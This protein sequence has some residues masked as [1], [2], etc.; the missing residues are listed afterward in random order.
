MSRLPSTGPGLGDGP[1]GAEPQPNWA[2]AGESYS[3]LT[4][5]KLVLFLKSHIRRGLSGRF[6]VLTTLGGLMRT[7]KLSI[8]AFMLG[9]AVTGLLA[10]VAA[11]GSL[12][13]EK[14]PP[15]DTNDPTYRLF[16][17][18]DTT[19][20]GEL[21]SFS[22]LGDVY[23]DPQDPAQELQHVFKIEYDKNRYFGR[24]RIYVRSVSKL[25]PQQLKTYTP[26]QIFDFGIKDEEKFEKI[27][28][29]PFGQPGDLY[30]QA[31]GDLPLH[32]APTTDAVRKAYELFVSQYVLP[33]LQ[34]K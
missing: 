19:R 27:E 13:R 2:G 21:K 14:T 12:G 29:G 25:S 11:P 4:H 24:F 28:P 10:T 34:K 6:T 16:Q 26:E 3:V 1:A 15:V 33:A 31:K 17:L 5:Q 30:F 7:P 8:T 22:V 23:P 32:T 18:L 9:M 20:G